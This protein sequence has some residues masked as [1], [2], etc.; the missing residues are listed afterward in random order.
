[1]VPLKREA[2]IPSLK[3]PPIRFPYLVSTHIAVNKKSLPS[4]SY[5]LLC[6]ELSF[7]CFIL[8]WW[9]GSYLSSTSYTL[10]VVVFEMLYV[11]NAVELNLLFAV[12]VSGLLF[13]QFA[14]R[15]LGNS[16]FLAC[17]HE[18]LIV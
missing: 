15:A 6:V 1:M 12:F 2:S 17:Q 7:V 9:E 14:N 13:V 10:L 3:R 5:F 18:K 16:R 8:L 4:L 11:L